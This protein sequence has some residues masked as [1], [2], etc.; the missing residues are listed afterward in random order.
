MAYD[1]EKL[2]YGKESIYIV[3]LLLT[4]C[5]QTAGVGAC[6]ATET[7]DEPGYPLLHIRERHHLTNLT[8]Q[9]GQ[10]TPAGRRCRASESSRL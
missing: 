4:G 7:G 10:T 5:F 6:G 1:N 3:D 2:K 9:C 8:D